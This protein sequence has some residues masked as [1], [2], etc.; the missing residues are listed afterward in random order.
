MARY[1]CSKEHYNMI[2]IEP[3][4][5]LPWL[6]VEPP[7]DAENGD[8]TCVVRLSPVVLYEKP[9]FIR[10]KQFAVVAWMAMGLVQ[11]HADERLDLR[12]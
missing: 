6:R 3:H 9:T 4:L 11:K 12:C 8:T 7:L 10:S 1:G 5:S 2:F